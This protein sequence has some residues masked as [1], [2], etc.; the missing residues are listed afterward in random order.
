MN[1]STP[2][3]IVVNEFNFNTSHKNSTFPIFLPK[4]CMEILILLN[5]FIPDGS[6]MTKKSINQ[7][8]CA[9]TS[10]SAL[11]AEQKSCQLPKNNLWHSLNRSSLLCRFI[12]N[13]TSRFIVDCCQLHTKCSLLPTRYEVINL[14][15]NIG[16]MSFIELMLHTVINGSVISPLY[17][18]ST[19]AVTLSFLSAVSCCLSVVSLFLIVSCVLFPLDI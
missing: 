6:K 19:I 7:F 8:A 18:N 16:F 15:S 10:M 3:N 13:Q 1:H 5:D 2:Q 4:I 14:L 17:R 9:S 11:E 12:G